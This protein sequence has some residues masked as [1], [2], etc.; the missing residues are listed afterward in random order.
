MYRTKVFETV[1]TLRQEMK[2]NTCKPVSVFATLF[3]LVFMG[4]V[5]PGLAGAQKESLHGDFSYWFEKGALFSVYG[6]QNA[7][8]EAFQ[9]AIEIEPE[10]GDAHF[11]IG[12]AYAEKGD[13]PKAIHAVNKALRIDPERGMY[14]YGR[15]WIHIRFGNR[16]Q[17]LSD[18]EEAANRGNPD[19]KE[20][21]LKI[22]PRSAAQ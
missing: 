15:G 21:L 19:A 18:M 1:S 16:D 4:F 11:N 6:N 10:N 7:A 9:K 2:M 5:M 12:I 17:G 13:Y 22:A 20:Y 3:F 14:H 8:I